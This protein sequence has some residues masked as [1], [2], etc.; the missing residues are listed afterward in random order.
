MFTHDR[1][2]STSEAGSIV[3]FGYVNLRVPDQREA[4]RYLIEG[5][6]LTRDPFRMVGTRNMWINVGNQQFHLPLGM[7]T[8]L[9]G[10]D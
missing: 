6:G 2:A 9:P 4:T 3:F 10:E 8:P 7:A 5:L 1:A